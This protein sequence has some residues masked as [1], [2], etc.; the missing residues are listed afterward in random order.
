MLY[1]KTVN[2]FKR[3]RKKNELQ[4]E[5]DILHHRFEKFKI[6]MKQKR[7]AKTRR[8]KTAT[9]FD[10][11]NDDKHSAHYKR[12]NETKNILSDRHEVVEGAICGAWEC[13][14]IYAC[15]DI[16][17]KFLLSYKRGTFLEGLYGNFST[18]LNKSDIRIK[19][20]FATNYCT[21][22]S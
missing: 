2:C 8:K 19:K 6:L 10:T 4:E 18:V 11:I 20:A 3:K 14:M 16:M 13:I 15:M 17:E 21:Y 5:Y 12:E 1:S 9:K 22:M 7:S